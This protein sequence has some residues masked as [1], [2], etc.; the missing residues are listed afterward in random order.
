MING[1]FTIKKL[2]KLE[3]QVLFYSLGMY[4]LFSTVL[5]PVYKIDENAIMA[6]FYPTAYSQ[7]WFITCYAVVMILSPYINKF[8]CC[9]QKKELEKFLII[10]IILWPVSKTFLGG[11]FAFNHLGRL[12]VLYIMA[13]YINL[14]VKFDSKAIKKNKIIM[15]VS[16]ALLVLSPVIYNTLWKITKVEDFLNN[17]RDLAS[18]SSILV[19]IVSVSMFV[20][21]LNRKKYNSNIINNISK[22]TLGVYLIHDNSLFRPYLWEKIFKNANYYSSKMLIVHAIFSII[23]VYVISSIIDY[24]RIILIEPLWMKLYDYLE[25]KLKKKNDSIKLLN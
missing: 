22:C 8:I 6:S 24:I 20:Y 13:A 7:Y 25:N 18:I 12:I 19:L 5:E 23:I 3:G 16:I 1:K 10:M 11:G 15:I 21:F 17:S 14:Y 2:W 4:I 9:M